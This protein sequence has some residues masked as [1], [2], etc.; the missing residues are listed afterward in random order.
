VGKSSGLI[1]KGFR[2][3]QKNERQGKSLPRREKKR[4]PLGRKKGG[5]IPMSRIM[6]AG[7]REGHVLGEGGPALPAT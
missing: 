7:K 5:S 1:I 2:V 6:F 3:A 4:L